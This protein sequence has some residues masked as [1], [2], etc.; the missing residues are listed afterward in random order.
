MNLIQVSPVGGRGPNTGVTSCCLHA[1][2]DERAIMRNSQHSILCILIYWRWT[3]QPLGKLQHHYCSSCSAS[4]LYIVKRNDLTFS[5]FIS[6]L[7]FT[8]QVVFL[9]RDTKLT[10]Q[11]SAKSHSSLTATSHSTHNSGYRLLW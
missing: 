7:T 10:A 6:S 9:P 5:V 11:L 8:L 3:S 1:V 2:Y 4:E